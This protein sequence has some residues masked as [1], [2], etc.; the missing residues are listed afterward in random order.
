MSSSPDSTSSL[1]T[2]RRDNVLSFGLYDSYDEKRPQSM[3]QPIINHQHHQQQHQMPQQ[4]CQDRTLKPDVEK[5]ALS[6]TSQPS[7]SSFEVVMQPN[8]A[9]NPIYVRNIILFL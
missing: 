4:L 6:L 5:T 9:T 3:E 8:A 7:A 2:T 1:L